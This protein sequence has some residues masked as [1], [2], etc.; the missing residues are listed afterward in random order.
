M[1]S[2]FGSNALTR[3][4]EVF[5]GKE[6]GRPLSVS[7]IVSTMGMRP[8]SFSLLLGDFVSQDYPLCELVVVLQSADAKTQL[9]VETEIS[10]RFGEGNFKL[11]LDAGRG[12]SRS[13]N[14]GMAA[15]S[16]DLLLLCDDDCRYPANAATTVVQAA[17]SRTWDAFSFDV[18]TSPNGPLLKTSAGDGRHP[19]SWRS[20]MRIMSVGLVVRRLLVE[21][22]GGL[23]DERFGL[24]TSNPTGEENIMLN[25]L[26]RRGCVAGHIPKVVVYHPPETSGSIGDPRVLAYAKG[27]MFRRL[28]G[29]FG[30]V[31]ALV[32]FG[33]RMRRRK[34]LQFKFWHL[35]EL[36]AGFAASPRGQGPKVMRGAD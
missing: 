1:I 11:L 25:D 29:I 8:E 3:N 2:L 7:F 22:W 6:K 19:H 32:F 21:R 33:T 9:D 12:L 4:D 27:A 14:L 20:R 13:R 23:M 17:G 10:R 18:A 28:F 24:G 34:G 35:R 5:V 30:A 31:P 36:A 26:A 16:N 15:A